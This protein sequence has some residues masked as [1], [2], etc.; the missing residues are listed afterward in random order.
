VAT[1]HGAQLID[2]RTRDGL[3]L[4]CR[5]LVYRS[6]AP[7]LFV[8]IDSADRGS[9]AMVDTAGTVREYARPGSQRSARNLVAPK[10]YADRPTSVQVSASGRYILVTYDRY[11][12]LHDDRMLKYADES[13]A[14]G[15][16]RALCKLTLQ[17]K[18]GWSTARPALC[19]ACGTST[20]R[21][22][23]SDRPASTTRA[24]ATPRP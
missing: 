10:G 6:K 18:R 8:G 24:I 12:V 15:A 9:F 5:P 2:P 14:A 7:P 20:L 11:L 4:D 21:R 17:P 22:R 13:P 3:A 19:C 23:R 1:K 16:L